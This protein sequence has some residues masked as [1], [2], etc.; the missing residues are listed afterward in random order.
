MLEFGDP[1]VLVLIG[2]IDDRSRLK[3]RPIV[4]LVPKF[5]R[6]VGQL[7]EPMVEEFVDRPGV[8]HLGVGHESGDLAVIGVEHDVD[9]GVFEHALEHPSTLADTRCS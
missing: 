7:A 1:R 3:H 6:P 5:E 2:I 9:V 8:D 4:G